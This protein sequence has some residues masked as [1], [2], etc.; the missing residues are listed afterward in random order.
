MRA[1]FRPHGRLHFVNVSGTTGGFASDLLNSARRAI[2]SAFIS[3]AVDP[4]RRRRWRPSRE[5]VSRAGWGADLP[6]RR[7][8]AAGPARVR[9]GQ[10]GRD[11]PHRDR[12]RLHRRRRRPA[13]VL[14][15]CRY[16]P[17]RQ[18]LERHRLQRAR[19]SL[20]QRSTRAAPAGSQAGRRRPGAGLQ[21]PDDRRSP[22]SATT[23]ARRRRPRGAG[24]RSSSF[25]AWKM[26]VDR[27]YP[28]DRH[29][30]LTLTPAAAREPLPAGHAWS[31]L[32]ED[33]RPQR[34]SAC[35]ACPG[36]ALI[37]LI[38]QIQP[39]RP[40]ADQAASATRRPKP[41]AQRQADAAS[42]R[43]AGPGRHR[44]EQLRRGRRGRSPRALPG[45]RG[46][47]LVCAR[48]A[49]DLMRVPGGLARWRSR[50]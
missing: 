46:Q 31:R 40:D 1:S 39:R 49:D 25:L 2:N 7:L 29:D 36:E 32:N 50:A 15:I 6:Q 21:R 12:Q 28:V 27:A 18:R 38:P 33:H 35:T 22:R 30:R 17:Q 11:P 16:P 24:A 13:I 41:T 44:A 34:R 20:R 23:P 45:R 8:P 5:I 10:G 43:R 26:A 14:G 42:K 37:R 3:V 48:V 47:L 19:R 4:G 9:H